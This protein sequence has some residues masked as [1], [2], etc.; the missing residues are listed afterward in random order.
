M[1]DSLPPKIWE[2]E[3]AV[4]NLSDSAGEGTHWVAYKKKGR[5]VNYFDSYGSLP[6]PLELL[7]Y[8][9]ADSDKIFYNDERYQDVNAWNCGHLCLAF[10]LS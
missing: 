9:C 5:V 1:R 6:P 10:L 7:R 4:V 8:F 3:A 2:N